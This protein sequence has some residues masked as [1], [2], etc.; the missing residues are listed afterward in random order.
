MD[1]DETAVILRGS[2]LRVTF[3]N[4]AT[5]YRVLR[6]ARDDGRLETVVGVFARV[7]PGAEVHVRGRREADARFG[8]RVVADAV[9]VLT[10]TTLV[11]LERFLGSGVVKGVGPV[12]ARRIVEQ[13]GEG[14]LA[15]LDEGGGR[16]AEVRGIGPKTA[17]A[18][19][20]A[21]AE[22]RAASDALMFL[23]GHGLTASMAHRLFQRFGA[24]TVDA[25]RARPFR[26]ADELPGLGFA[27]TDRI[28]RALGA[29]RRDPERLEA[30]ALHALAAATEAGHTSVPREA[31]VR[32]AA[33]LAGEAPEALSGALDRVALASR[34]VVEPSAGGERVTTPALFHAEEGLA[35]AL[36]RLLAAP[37][38]PLGDP[39]LAAAAF[40]RA[41]GLRLAGAQ[42]R[43]VEAASRHK[44]LVLTGG[45]GVGKTTLVRALLALYGR[46]N[47]R[48][49]LAAPT[50]RAAK[51][52]AEATGREASTLHRLLEVDPRSG[53]FLRN[54]G[55]PLELGA[56]VVD[57]ASMLDVELARALC[58]ALPD[59]ARLVL[60]GD[61]DQLPSVGPGAVLRDLLRS[62][63]VPSVRLDQ[64]FRQAGGGLILDNAHRIRAGEPP[65]TSEG[66]EGDFFVVARRDPDGARKT[67]R[68]LV[69]RHL[70]RAF[71]LDPR[72]E[73][74]VLTPMNKGAAGV[75]AL[76]DELQQALNPEGPGLRRGPRLW[77][78][79]DKVMQTK[80]DYERDVYNGDIGFVAAVDERGA[81]LSVR[82]DDRLVS[83]GEERLDDLALAYAVSIHKSQG[84]EYPA[85]VVP[86]LRQHYA[87]LSRNLLYTAVTRGK[88]LV[89]LVAD[90]EAI[91]LALAEGRQDERQTA[92]AGRLR[93]ALERAAGGGEGLPPGPGLRARSSS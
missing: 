36:A 39:A 22:R 3:E 74:Q 61:V 70:P 92:L 19:G 13:F 35:R 7:T 11:G 52:L 82:L 27:A 8:P 45:P 56:L 28:A 26:L 87:L 10:P 41:A 85:V 42:A 48:A 37:A 15:A 79:G 91:A 9:T 69:C 83:Y 14:A 30:A 53:A 24:R 47:L 86:W 73:V 75:L 38:P 67:V 63:L 78:V 71:G 60:V 18:L 68:D 40:E 54:R 29:D 64:V 72:R 5:G 93:A 46:A 62:G 50:G 65:L 33:A 25:V 16:L 88:R 21:W 43:A 55:R 57:E 2:V 77:R 76:N 58:E 4:E 44:V 84:S 12:L 17:L 6:V 80:N 59:R 32:E 31:L 51:R 20:R 49:G 1:A 89:V 81:R 23:R 90:P 34:A 66:P